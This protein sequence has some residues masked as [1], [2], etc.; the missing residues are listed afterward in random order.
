MCA[1]LSNKN[2]L[3]SQY[4]GFEAVKVPSK[5]PALNRISAIEYLETVELMWD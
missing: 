1:F 4:F 5:A 2:Q 3:T